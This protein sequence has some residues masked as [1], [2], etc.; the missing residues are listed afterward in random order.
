MAAITTRGLKEEHMENVV[1]LID[2]SLMN[3][4]NE[5]ELAA[6]RKKVNELM[7]AFN[8]YPELG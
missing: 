8:L 7:S 3:A 2:R 6:I 5:T 4:D 1:D